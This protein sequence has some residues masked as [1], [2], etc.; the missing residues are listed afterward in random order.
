MLREKPGGESLR[1]V[2]YFL[3][4]PFAPLRPRI[5]TKSF[6]F[7][8]AAFNTISYATVLFST[9]PSK[10]RFRFNLRFCNFPSHFKQPNSI[11][12][13]AAAFFC[14]WNPFLADWFI[15]LVAPTVIQ[16]AIVFKAPRPYR[17]YLRICLFS[18]VCLFPCLVISF[19]LVTAT[20]WP[21][22]SFVYATGHGYLPVWQFGAR[23]W[24]NVQLLLLYYPVVDLWIFI[25]AESVKIHI[26]S[27][28]LK[29]GQ[30][31]Q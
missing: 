26:H 18:F 3:Q 28:S 5:N 6:V 30:K 7:V 16:S 12:F 29:R 11:I 23:N 27:L 14:L 9:P 25:L 22:H 1:R 17:F 20:F 4:T 13:C 10:S 31:D 15:F 19:P 21:D 8:K 24:K 2:S